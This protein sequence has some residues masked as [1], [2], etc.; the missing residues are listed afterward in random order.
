[1]LIGDL[2]HASYANSEQQ[3]ID[4]VQNCLRPWASNDEQALRRDVL[5]GADKTKYDIEYSFNDLL[6]GDTAARFAS[7]QTAVTHGISTINEARAAENLPPVANGDEL[8]M[9]LQVGRVLA[10]GALEAPKSAEPPPVAPEEPQEDDE[11]EEDTEEQEE[12]SLQLQQQEQRALAGVE[13]RAMIAQ[14]YIETIAEV[15]GRTVR[16]EVRDVRKQLE[17]MGGLAMGGRLDEFLRWLKAYEAELSPYMRKSLGPVLRTMMLQVAGVAAA[18]IGQQSPGLT[19]ALRAWVDG[20]TERYGVEYGSESFNQLRA[21]AEETIAESG[22]VDAAIDGRLGEWDEKRAGKEGFREGVNFSNAAAIA[23]WEGYRVEKLRVRAN[24][25]ACGFCRRLDG[26]VV[27]IRETIIRKGDVLEGDD[28]AT[29]EV[30]RDIKH[31]QFHEG[32]T[33]GMTAEVTNG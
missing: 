3:M 10:D 1:V 33:C 14:A 25:G 11:P 4:F 26:K 27:S 28:G 32:C 12:R 20:Y 22:D 5:I 24:A 19:E 16:K 6:R 18:E 30:S 31:P 2:A 23:V 21:L 29:M 8:Y 15:L 9:P 17:S 7:Y 13:Q